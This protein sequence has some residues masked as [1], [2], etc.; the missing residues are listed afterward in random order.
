VQ[1][2]KGSISVRL[3]LG[4]AALLALVTCTAAASDGGMRWPFTYQDPVGDGNGGPDIVSVVEGAD[5]AA[6]WPKRLLQHR[7]GPDDW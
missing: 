2:P 7:S 3:L 1:A 6:S 5:Q 4:A